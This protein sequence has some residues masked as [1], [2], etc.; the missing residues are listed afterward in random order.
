VQP[1]QRVL[2]RTAQL[3]GDPRPRL[4]QEH[5]HPLVVAGEPVLGDLGRLANSGQAGM[6][7]SYAAAC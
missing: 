6:S 3:R 1:G 2:V 4:G 7:I 5:L